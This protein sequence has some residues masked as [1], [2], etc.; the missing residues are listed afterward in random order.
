MKLFGSFFEVP[1]FFRTTP[2]TFWLCP[3]Q[4]SCPRSWATLEEKAARHGR[5]PWELTFSSQFR[6]RDVTSRNRRRSRCKVW[7][8]QKTPAVI[9]LL[10]KWTTSFATGA[11]FGLQVAVVLRKQTANCKHLEKSLSEP[12]Q[13]FTPST[14]KNWTSQHFFHFFNST[15]PCPRR[16]SSRS[17]CLASMERSSP[18]SASV[19]L[20]RLGRFLRTSSGRGSSRNC[21]SFAEKEAGTARW[22][23]TTERSWKTCVTQAGWGPCWR[24]SMRPCSSKG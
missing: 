5:S 7:K 15:E 22:N 6:F 2:C 1:D 18:V 3:P 24:C 11:F 17:G 20:W 8:T 23:S 21:R 4:P 16:S 19:R 13:N 10:D 12:K 14:E 9:A